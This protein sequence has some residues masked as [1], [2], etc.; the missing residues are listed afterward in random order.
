METKTCVGKHG[1]NKMQLRQTAIDHLKAISRF[2]QAQV[3]LIVPFIS[4]NH[5]R[6]QGDQVVKTWN[7]SNQSTAGI[8]E[9]DS[10]DGTSN[11]WEM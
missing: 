5:S 2:F 8:S 6:P 4:P 1:S 11:M 3:N 9:G 7:N 10:D